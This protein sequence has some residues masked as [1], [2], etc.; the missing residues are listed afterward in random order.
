MATKISSIEELIAIARGNQ[1]IFKQLKITDAHYKQLT[2]E[3]YLNNNRKYI[4]TISSNSVNAETILTK[5]MQVNTHEL[6]LLSVSFYLNRY[7]LK[8]RHNKNNSD[9]DLPKKAR[10]TIDATEITK[11]K[12]RIQ[13]DHYKND[14]PEDIVE[15]V[16]EYA[17]CHLKKIP[18][19][20]DLFAS[21]CK[22]TLRRGRGY[23]IL[24]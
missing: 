14:L 20:W 16:E 3:R 22:Q 7:R 18:S 12:L 11:K 8:D 9:Q 10:F 2:V 17:K 4:S 24:L 23:C 19:L 5:A 21:F 1:D 13:F 15:Q 6:E